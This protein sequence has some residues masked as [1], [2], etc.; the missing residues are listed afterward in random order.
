MIK[1]VLAVFVS[2]IF[3]ALTPN[4]V[5]AEIATSDVGTPKKH[6]RHAARHHRALKHGAGKSHAKVAKAHRKHR[7][8][9]QHIAYA[10]IA[11]AILT[12][13]DLAGLH[14]THDALALQSNV[15]LVV[16][17]SNS[18][19]LFE[20]NANVAL[21]IASITKLMTSLV[22]VEAHQNHG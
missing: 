2:L 7:G 9:A 6:S 4:A 20:K 13:G 16:D 10:P 15:A 14:L 8:A 22:V 19:V 5:S 17:Q 18:Q 12:V 3:V 1:S 11:P 21:P